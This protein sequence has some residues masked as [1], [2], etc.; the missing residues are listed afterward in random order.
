ML[1]AAF[2]LNDKNLLLRHGVTDLLQLAQRRGANLHKL[3]H[4]TQ[5][6]EQDLSLA[7]SR[8]HHSD[9]LTLFERSQK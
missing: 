2:T 3:L 1:P 8:C 6:F 7:D 4:G 9:W 5:I